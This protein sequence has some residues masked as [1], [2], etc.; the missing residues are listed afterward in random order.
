MRVLITGMG[1]ELGTRVAQLLEA[2][3]SV[4][5]ICGLDIDPP[6]HRLRRADFFRVDPRLRH[7]T[8][9]VARDFMPTVVAHLD[10]F[11][12]DARSGPRLAGA[13]TASGAVGLFQAL[14][15]M[16]SV[17]SV[18]VRSG[19]EVYG[20]HRSAPVCPDESSVADPSSAYGHAARHVEQVAQDCGRQLDVP[21]A[22]L[23]MAPVVGP[24]FPS[25][26]GRL[27]RLP[28]VP[29][30]MFSDPPFSVLH[31]TDAAAAV[32][33]AIMRRPD[34]PVNVVAP[35]AVTMTQAARMGRRVPIPVVGPG[36]RGARLAAELAGAPVPE[37]VAE[38]LV[39]GRSADG[40]AAADLLGVMPQ[41]ATAEVV[42]HLF[43]WPDVIT[44]RPVGQAA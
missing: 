26:L 3:D 29:F 14:N 18:V 36:W 17:E 41:R 13:L 30:S 32:V 33:A 34:G 22:L 16:T 21:V 31:Q 15:G 44:I 37:H 8:M 39:R 35:G 27:L 28:V 11:E 5:E 4:A 38:L 10:V 25:P 24:H 20:R 42:D 43:D 19:I 7:R 2:D 12:P 40:S 9:E 23:R 6:R 1:G